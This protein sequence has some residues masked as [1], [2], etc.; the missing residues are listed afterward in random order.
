[1]TQQE[2]LKEL[3]DSYDDDITYDD[4]IATILMHI[5]SS[6]AIIADSMS[7][8]TKEVEEKE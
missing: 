3:L 8:R 4:I 6:L 5:A 7:G 1:M 2:K